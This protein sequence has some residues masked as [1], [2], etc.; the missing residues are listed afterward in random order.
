MLKCYEVKGSK[1]VFL[2]IYPS[3]AEAKART[4]RQHITVKGGVSGLDHLAGAKKKK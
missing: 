3:V 2:G 1:E 4:G